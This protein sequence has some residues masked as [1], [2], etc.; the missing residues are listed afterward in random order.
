MF[1]LVLQLTVHSGTCNDPEN[2]TAIY[3]YGDMYYPE[4]TD[5]VENVTMMQCAAAEDTVTETT[6]VIRNYT[7]C[8]CPRDDSCKISQA[9]MANFILTFQWCQ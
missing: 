7:C 2:G 4:C 3:F 8:D 5:G 1:C 9:E 6:W